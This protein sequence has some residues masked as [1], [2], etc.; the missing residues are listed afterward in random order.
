MLFSKQYKRV[1]SYS[2][3]G[4]EQQRDRL[5]GWFSADWMFS[6]LELKILI[7]LLCM[8]LAMALTSFEERELVDIISLPTDADARLYMKPAPR[9][10]TAAVKC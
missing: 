2:I 9:F 8:P 3:I 6:E 10:T 5:F 4:A 1:P 7:Q